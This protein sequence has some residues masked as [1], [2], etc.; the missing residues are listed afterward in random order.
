MFALGEKTVNQKITKHEIVC[1]HIVRE[2]RG[3]SVHR[4]MRTRLY[5]TKWYNRGPDPGVLEVISMGLCGCSQ[6]CH[7]G[8]NRHQIRRSRNGDRGNILYSKRTWR[9]ATLMER[10][11]SK[12]TQF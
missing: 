11:P 1:K 9:L 12:P 4:L 3:A 8:T 10:I 6:T 2:G 5:I 7:K